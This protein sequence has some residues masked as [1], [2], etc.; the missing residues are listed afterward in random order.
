MG[1]TGVWSG[2][3]QCDATLQQ[4]SC[5]HIVRESVM[6]SSSCAVSSQSFIARLLGY[7]KQ[8]SIA[9]VAFLH[10]SCV[11]DIADFMVLFVI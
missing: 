2:S 9:V 5:S 11:P 4:P 1:C 10:A 6:Y 7:T 3:C 8:D